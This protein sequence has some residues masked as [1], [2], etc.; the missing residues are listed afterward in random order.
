MEKSFICQIENGIGRLTFNRPKQANSFNIHCREDMVEAVDQITAAAEDGTLRVVVITGEGKFFSTGGDLSAFAAQPDKLVEAIDAGIDFVHP[1]LLKLADLPVPVISAVNGPASGAG[2]GFALC[3]DF[4][5]AADSALLRGGYAA[6]GLT[7]DSGAS[8]FLARRVGA[9]KAKEIFMLNRAH[10]AQECLRLGI[11]DSVYPATQLTEEIEALAQ[12]LASGPT[13]SYGR[14]KA[15][16]DH[17]STQDLQTHLD[18]ER[19]L[20][21][22]SARSADFQEGLRAFVEKRPPNFSGST[23]GRKA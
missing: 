10:D 2:I 9:A 6:L 8:Y 7:P 12:L 13:E 18:M 21:L 11:V 4:V 1:L 3:A 15:L 16:C 19:S 22:D 23:H 20:M 14:I 5:L 17:A